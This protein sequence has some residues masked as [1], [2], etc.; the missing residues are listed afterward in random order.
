MCI[1][2]HVYQHSEQMKGPV[3]AKLIVFII[4]AIAMC[5]WI[6][7]TAGG[8]GEVAR[9]PGKAKGSAGTWLLIHFCL[10]NAA[11][12]ATFASN[13]ADFQHYAEN[14]S[15]VVIGNLLGFSLSNL[16]V[17]IVGSL[18]GS[19][20]QAVFSALIWNL[21]DYPDQLQVTDYSAKNCAGCF[22]TTACFACGAIFSSIFENSL[23][24]G[25]NIVALFPK[26]LVVRKVFA[27]CTV[28]SLAINTSYPLG[29]ASIF[30]SFL[31]SYQISARL[32]R[33]SSYAIT[34]SSPAAT[35]K[36][37]TYTLPENQVPIITFM[38]G[39]GARI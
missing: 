15:D 26:Y 25:N 27:T 4:S 14:P 29:S 17:S 38:V 11:N 24:A 34:T 31:A 30:I 6:L 13:A 1:P 2:R 8:I 10:L 23:P 21:L 12:C 32:S 36:S 7:T 39:I 35:L 22:F 19:S 9:Q 16:I 5:A 37:T 3:Y 18:I 28:L 33:A 20:S